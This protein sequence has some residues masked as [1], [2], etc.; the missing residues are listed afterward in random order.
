M[1]LQAQKRKLGLMEDDEKSNLDENV[2]SKRQNFGADGN[3]VATSLGKNRGM[4]EFYQKL[5]SMWG[6]LGFCSYPV[7]HSH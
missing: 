5:L 6:Y 7:F 2:S 4:L 1:L 3:N